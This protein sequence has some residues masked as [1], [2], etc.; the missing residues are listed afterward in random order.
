MTLEQLI[1]SASSLSHAVLI[2]VLM[3]MSM[4]IQYRNLALWKCAA[5]LMIGIQSLFGLSGDRRSDTD[6]P[7]LDQFLSFRL[8]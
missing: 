7:N 3:I 1:V 4:N 6:Q 8:P 5:S 2:I